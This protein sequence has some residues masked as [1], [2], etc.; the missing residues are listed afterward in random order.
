MT[1][2][3]NSLVMPHRSTPSFLQELGVE[4]MLLDL[5]DYPTLFIAAHV[6]VDDGLAQRGHIGFQSSEPLF[7]GLDAFRQLKQKVV[8][9]FVSHF[10]V[11]RNQYNIIIDIPKVISDQNHDY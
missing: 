8:R 5:G 3:V 6:V 10:G 2:I 11:N 1:S 4:N 7:D 9:D